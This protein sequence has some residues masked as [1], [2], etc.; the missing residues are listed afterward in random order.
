MTISP[1]SH[2]KTYLSDILVSYSADLL[3]IGGGLGN[4][5]ERV[6]EKLELVLLVLGGLN[7]DTWLH[8][9]SA[10]NLLTNEV[11]D[12]DLEKTSL[13][14][15]LDV[16]V[17]WEMG[18]DV[19]H[20]VLEALGDTDDEVV[21]EGT[22]SSESGDVL[23]GTVVELDVDDIL[24]WV[25]EVDCQVGKVLGELSC[26]ILLDTAGCPFAIANPY[27]LGPRPSQVL[28]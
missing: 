9:D 2:D 14:V 19:S 24:L 18:V 3:D 25:G 17:D 20:L 11:S 4:V 27:L 6:S 10:D 1:S 12:L 21:D 5:L 7:L 22:D 8:D 26:F 28:T 15:L 23:A 13:V 16:D